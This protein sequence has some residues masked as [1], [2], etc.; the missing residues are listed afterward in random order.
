M[1]GETVGE[2]IQRLSKLDPNL[3]VIVRDAQGLDYQPSS[4]FSRTVTAQEARESAQEG[5][6]LLMD[7]IDVEVAIICIDY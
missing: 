2:L 6:E 4:V 7:Y 1:A 3:P 5:T